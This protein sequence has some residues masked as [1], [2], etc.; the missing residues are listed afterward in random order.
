MMDDI[1]KPGG[2]VI[3]MPPGTSG[4][5]WSGAS[6][7]PDV[8]AEIEKRYPAEKYGTPI[9]INPKKLRALGKD[10]VAMM[11]MV[12]MS[13]ARRRKEEEATAANVKGRVMAPSGPPFVR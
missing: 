11:N 5:V 1:V 10:H 7:P 6:I 3:R 4:P 9:G 2:A 8:A 13:E 12:R